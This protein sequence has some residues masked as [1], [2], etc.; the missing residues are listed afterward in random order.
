MKDIQ[1][2]IRTMLKQ[3]VYT[4]IVALSLGLGIGANTA[5]FTLINAVFLQPLPVRNISELATI[6]TTD[7]HNPGLLP[8]STP[9]Y[10]DFRDKNAVFSELLAFSG[11]GAALSTDD[12]PEQI[13]GDLVS[14]NYFDMLGVKAALG[15]TILPEEDGAPGASPVIVLSHAF[16]TRQYGGSS[17]VLGRTLK[18]NGYPFKVIGVAPPKFIG[19][20]ALRGPEF[21]APMSMYPQLMPQSEWFENRRFLWLT[22]VGRLRPG[23]GIEQAQVQLQT[24]GQNLQKQFPDDNRDRNVKLLP[25]TDA[26]IDP[27]GRTNIV[28]AG[29]LLMTVVA[30]VLLIACANVANLQLVRASARKKEIAI[31]LSMG[32][33]R[34]RL[35]RQ[36]M[37]ESILLASLGG[38][39][40]LVLA[41]WA[42]T[43]L[44]SFRPP[45]LQANDLDLALDT[46]VLLFTLGIS[47]F[48][49]LLFG[50]APALQTATP[51]M[52]SELKERNAT[53]DRGST[54]FTLRNALV[55]GQVALSL[56]ALIGAGLFIRSMQTAQQA[57]LGFDASQIGTFFLN[58]QGQG[59][60]PERALVF[61]RQA[62]ERVQAIPGIRSAAFASAVPLGFGGVLRSVFLDGREPAP[63]NRGVLVLVNNVAP[64]YFETMRIPV[65]R[66]RMI[67]DNDRKD[68]QSVAIVNETMAKKFWPGEDPIGKR[69][70]FFGDP[71]STQVVGV[72]KDNKYLAISEDPR[73]CAFV[74]VTQQYAGQMELVFNSSGDPSQMIGALRREVQSLDP[75][76]VITNSFTMR[77]LI[78]RSLW[79]PRM[80]AGLLAIFGLLALA[81]S[82]IGVYGVMAYAVVQRTNELGI[83]MA[84][85]ASTADVL[86]LVTMQGLIV[87]GSGV[88]AGLAVAFGSARLIEKLL[89]GVKPSD[90]ATFVL[91]PALMLA[92]ALVA[93]L[94]PA[95]RATQIDPVL[96]LRSE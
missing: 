73:A 4:A 22:V 48:S 47:L 44:W 78:D 24:I 67:D 12:E 61:Y 80:G 16:W 34:G 6:F 19:I 68:T 39:V 14:G 30:L 27:N 59:Y 1:F 50:L 33:T 25:L 65:L 45:F 82:S 17:D 56:V 91:T 29:S 5:I 21:W 75:N 72:V 10:R 79:A 84:I 49:G 54:L 2:A 43:L 64:G 32:A 83:R 52:I 40:G 90:P 92:V 28:G 9:N 41:S 87:V 36:L 26:V 23:T 3:P 37:V 66:G 38:V 13:F 93:I 89:Y 69:F 71:V 88:L 60:S 46:H 58:P 96:A 86:K 7:P 57:E 35:L 15:R 77:Q 76:L 70:H 53:V 51:D 95:R 55:A 20:N 18:L 85:G 11:V 63:G 94:L 8:L 42:R 74:P 31:R 81:L 62:R